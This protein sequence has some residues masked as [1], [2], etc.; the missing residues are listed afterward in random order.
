MY[1][2]LSDAFATDDTDT[3]NL[4]RLPC[5][6]IFH[7]CG[8]LA[9]MATHPSLDQTLSRATHRA[10]A[11]CFRM[12][13]TFLQLPLAPE[14]L[15]KG[16]PCGLDL[17][18]PVSPPPV[19]RGQYY[20]PPKCGTGRARENWTCR[21]NLWEHLVHRVDVCRGWTVEDSK[22]LSERAKVLSGLDPLEYIGMLL[23]M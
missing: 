20:S 6:Q 19:R 16:E 1:Q 10:D 4:H 13:D 9:G 15:R 8:Y 3:W 21:K 12:I 18:V 2:F 22:R 23:A 7:E 11:R 5:V 14:V 17:Q